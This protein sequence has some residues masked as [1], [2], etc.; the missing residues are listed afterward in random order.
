MAKQRL[1]I[2]DGFAAAV[3]TATEI[4][5]AGGVM[6]FPTETVYGIGVASDDSEAL[7]KLRRLKRR[8]EGKPFQFLVADLTM[9]ESLGAVFPHPA[10]SLAAA[11]WPGP[12]TLAVPDSTGENSLG[13]RIPNAPFVLALCRKLAKAIVSSSANPA[14]E[15]PPLDADSADVFGDEADLLVDGGRILAGSPSTVVKCLEDGFEILR[16]GAIGAEAIAAAWR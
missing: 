5:A 1:N 6:L 3:G 13:I 10:K 8:D 16:P 12:L 11:F 4:L 15:P 2:A 9:A 7:V 14:G